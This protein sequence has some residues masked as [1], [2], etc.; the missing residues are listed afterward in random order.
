MEISIITEI[1]VQ[2]LRIRAYNGNRYDVPHANDLRKI[3][4]KIRQTKYSDLARAITRLRPTRFYPYCQESQ[5]LDL[6]KE[7]LPS[8]RY[9]HDL[10]PPMVSTFAC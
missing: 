4:E 1:I 9:M 8:Q 3:I 2:L 10:L 7:R 5:D 6:E